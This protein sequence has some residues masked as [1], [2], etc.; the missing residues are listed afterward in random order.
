[1]PSSWVTWLELLAVSLV[2]KERMLV[3]ASILQKKL[4]WVASWSAVLT[5]ELVSYSA[6]G[7]KVFPTLVRKHQIGAFNYSASYA[8]SGAH[9]RAQLLSEFS[10]SASK[11]TTLLTRNS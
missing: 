4:Y 5:S 9:S 6:S 3:L 10:Y 8:V 7:N 11:V 2:K 1:M